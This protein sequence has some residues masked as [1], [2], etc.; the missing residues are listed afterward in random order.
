MDR[1]DYIQKARAFYDEHFADAEC[2]FIAGSVMRGEGGPHSDV[3]L[4]VL[5]DSRYEEPHRESHIY[6]NVPIE[7]FVH[8]EQAQDY[9]LEGDRKR[10]MNVMPS[11]ITEGIVIGRNSELAEQRKAIARRIT[12]QGPPPLNETA[13]LR[14]RYVITD[15]CDDL[16]DPRCRGQVMGILSKLFTVLGDF[17]LRVQNHWSGDGKALIKRLRDQNADYAAR[18]EQVF[19]QAF[20]GDLAP[21]LAFA[22]ETLQPYGGFHWA[23]DWQLAS[24]DWREFEKL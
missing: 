20:R 13:Q 16:R 1:D 12:E 22:E 21:L 4:V 8:N 7:V 2:G 24:S 14:A 11:M 18:Y 3:D 15:L 6:Q 9:F 19:D 10:G 17:Y 5:Y 23:G